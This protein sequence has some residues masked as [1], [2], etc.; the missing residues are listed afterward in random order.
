MQCIENLALVYHTH[1]H[2]K[3]CLNISSLKGASP[4]ENVLLYTK[5]LEANTPTRSLQ[6]GKHISHP[7]M[8]SIHFGENGK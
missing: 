7:N 2:R 1:F 3:A 4:L 6:K 8:Q 5:A